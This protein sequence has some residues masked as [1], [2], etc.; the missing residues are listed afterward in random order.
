[1][2]GSRYDL[3][4]MRKEGNI[5]IDE[6]EG[7]CTYVLVVGINEYANGSPTLNLDNLE[8]ACHDAECLVR[9]FEYQAERSKRRVVVMPLLDPS[10]EE[11]TETVKE[12]VAVLTENAVF[13]VFFSGHAMQVPDNWTYIV[14]ANPNGF[15]MF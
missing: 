9:A 3:V 13:M 11:I 1:M 15:E 6:P 12:I 4:A 2:V 5:R 8:S 10:A 7:P 14:G